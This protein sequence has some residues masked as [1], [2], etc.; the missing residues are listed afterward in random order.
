MAYIDGENLIA[1]TIKGH[2]NFDNDNVAQ[3]KW[4]FLNRGESDHHVVLKPGVPELERISK[5]VYVVRQI[6]IAE[7]W[8]SYVD[9]GT[10]AIALY[11]YVG[12]VVTQIENNQK[13]G[14]TGGIIQNAS[15]A[16][17]SE[18]EEMW[19]SGGGPAWLRQNVNILWHEQ[20]TA[21]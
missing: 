9:D 20:V 1:A 2:A 21:S 19:Q 6:T 5:N 15:A 8:K 3:G 4:T 13:L 12:N 17:V 11:G 16:V 18:V 14:D 10:T 7:V